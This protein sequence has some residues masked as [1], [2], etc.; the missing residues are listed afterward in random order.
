MV[1]PEL[2]HGTG[3]MTVGVAAVPGLEVGVLV[4]ATHGAG[5]GTAGQ[6]VSGAQ[7]GGEGQGATV[8][9]EASGGHGGAHGRGLTTVE[10][11]RVRLSAGLP[12]RL[13]LL[14]DRA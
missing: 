13:C 14:F 12:S 10:V 1:V 11:V 7:V 5:Q 9:V 3:Q 2:A 4:L 6:A 8:H